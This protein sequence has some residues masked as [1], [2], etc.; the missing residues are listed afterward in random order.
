MIAALRP[1]EAFRRLLPA[2]ALA[3]GAV[4]F[5]VLGA[6]VTAVAGLFGSKGPAV[7]LG[8]A[9]GPPLA[10]AVLAVP[11]LG[12]LLV[13]ATFPVGATAV[14]T[15]VVSV[16]T[17]ELAVLVVAGLV[18]VARVSGRYARAVWSPP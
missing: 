4:G 15:P 16:Q 13:L 18:G 7:L 1:V 10:V 14:P 17:V 3:V 8:L 11:V 9:L 12:P 6:G 5:F 2:V